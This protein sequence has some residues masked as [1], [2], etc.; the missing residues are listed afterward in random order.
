MPFINT[1][2]TFDGIDSEDMY[3]LKLIKLN[4][5]FFEQNFGVPRMTIKEKIKGRKKP[6]FYGLEEDVLSFTVILAKE[7]SWT[8]KE[9]QEIIKWLFQNTY[10][11][12]ISLD[13][14]NIIFKCIAVGNPKFYNNSLNQGYAEIQ[15]ECDAPHAWSPISIQKFDLSGNTTSTIIE[16]SNKSNIEKYYYPEIEFQLQDDSTSVKLENLSDGGRVFEFTNL[17]TNETVY[18]NNATKHIISDTG[19]YRLSNLTNKQ[20]LRLIYGVN[21]IKVT[22]KCTLQFRSQYPI[23]V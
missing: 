8:Y 11:E 5:D 12:F 9:R 6:Y 2:F 16:L 22:G 19:L 4:T 14:P 21:Q 23:A 10:K 7:T 13:T 15:F 18:V 20:F 3:G 1:A 17:Q